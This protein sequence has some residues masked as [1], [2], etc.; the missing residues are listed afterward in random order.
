[1]I[2]TGEREREEEKSFSSGMRGEN[3]EGTNGMGKLGS[4]LGYLLG[5][6]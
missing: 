4:E 3:K 5:L 2:V 1:L 6:G